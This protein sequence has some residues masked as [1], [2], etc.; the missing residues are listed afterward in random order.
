MSKIQV[1]ICNGT[2]CF[3]MGAEE[4]QELSTQIEKKFKDKVEVIVSSCLG[5]CSLNNENVKS[6]YVKID[7]EIIS[8][9][10]AEK[11]IAALEKKVK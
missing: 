11:V 6:P 8:E 7:D 3:I 1:K 5:L 2:T 9:A 10:T 4:F